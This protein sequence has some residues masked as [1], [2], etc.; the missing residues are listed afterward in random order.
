MKFFKLSTLRKGELLVTCLSLITT[1]ALNSAS[2]T[3]VQFQT[4]FGDFD[5]N[6]YD[7]KTPNTVAN[8]LAYVNAGD[9]SNTVIHRSVTDFIIQGGGFIYNMSWPLDNANSNAAVS[10]E[11]VFSNVRGTIAMAK[12]SGQADS[13]TNQ[14]FF[15]MADN[16][17][18]GA[19][20]D[21]QN[22]GFT[23]FGEVMGNGMTIVDQ[24][25]AVP[26]FNLGGALTDIPLENFANNGTDP[27][28]TNL[29]I[30][31][32]ILILDADPDTATALT[33]P[34]NNSQNVTPPPTQP[35]SSGGGGSFGV[36]LL[37]LLFISSL[38]KI[39][40]S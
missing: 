17:T 27:D 21:V 38:R 35:V 5:V 7:K 18:T 22:S 4:N 8:F 34:L 24:I 26:T 28:G 20:L 29:V 15:N 33:P 37:G 6:L 39:V 19:A 10:N 25:G 14:W 3:I 9:Y 40:K 2:A 23:V 11:P 1:I 30:I 13:A 32:S 31:N 36:L 12:L 16:S